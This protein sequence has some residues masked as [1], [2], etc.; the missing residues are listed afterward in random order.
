MAEKRNTKASGSDQH[1]F[2][3]VSKT[4]VNFRVDFNDAIAL[5]QLQEG[6]IS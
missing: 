1:V 4:T 2:D 5:L 6:Y 3:R